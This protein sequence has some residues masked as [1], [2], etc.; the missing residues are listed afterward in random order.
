MTVTVQNK[1]IVLEYTMRLHLVYENITGESVNF[2][3][4]ASMKQLTT[5]LLATIIASAQKQ[6]IDINF[7]YDDYM[8]WLDDNGGYAVINDFAIWFSKELQAKYS[9][10]AEK[11]QEENDL[12]SSTKKS[13]KAK[14]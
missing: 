14:N 5:M 9:L 12:P 8:N 6:H 3:N 1:E 13:K 7:T 4:M 10:L 11:I 2:E